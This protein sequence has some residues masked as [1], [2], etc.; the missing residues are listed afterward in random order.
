MAVCLLLARAIS[1]ASSVEQIYTAALDALEAGLDVSRSSILLFDADDV[2]RF[3]AS[4]GLS[5]TYRAAVEGHT[6]WRPDT[7]NPQ[8]IVISDVAAEPSLRALLPTIQAEG[9][10]ALS[11]I[12]LVSRCRVIG[13]FMLYYSE[14][15]TLAPDEAQLADLIAA[16]VAFAVERT[17]AEEQARLSEERLRFALDAASMGTWDW[18]LT[19]QS[20]RWSDNLE[21]LHA[22]APGT[23]DGTFASYEREI[24]PDDRARVLA[25]ARRAID[26]GIPHDVEY[27]IVGSNGDIRW[28]E[29]K[30]RVEYERGKPV[31]MTGVCM[32]VTRRKEAELARLTAAEEASRLKDEFLAMLS[33]ELRTPLNAILGWV[34]I[35]A[36]GGL[37]K[38][39]V[40]QAVDVIGRNA[41]L[42]A[43]LIEDILDVSRIITGKMKVERAPLHV[44]Q[45]VDTALNGVLPAAGAKQIAVVRDIPADLPPIEGDPKRLQQVFGNVLSNAIKFTP[46][47]G[48]VEIRCALDGDMLQIEVQDSGIGISPDF[49]PY[50]FDRFRQADSRSTRQ[51]AGLGLGLAIAHHLLEL[52]HG[53]IHVRSA[54][55]GCGTTFEIRLPIGSGVA[56]VV[57]PADDVANDQPLDLRL[58]GATVLIVDDQ[59]D[60]R[61]LL[62]ALFDRCGADVLQAS[63]AAAALETLDTRPVHLLVADLAMPDIDGFDLI[64]R[65]RRT[66]KHLPAV[67]VSAYARPEDRHRAL[68]AGYSAYCS[69][70]LE[71]TEFLQAVGRVLTRWPLPTVSRT[72]QLLAPA[73]SADVR[74]GAA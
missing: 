31:R 71:T 34:Q 13:K 67:A 62:S 22:L 38:E 57:P 18:D 44:Q 30:G 10:A 24:H 41:K 64:E 48:R 25:S 7:P 28:V 19:T 8:R 53:S 66:H 12:P 43:R 49:L 15:H 32:I 59:Q 6:P 42:Q 9:I 74:P 51:H 2:M 45:I 35:L 54:G 23:F 17:R 3:K 65:V 58:D 27:R 63:S 16:Q 61:D 56:A 37:S 20:V 33:H 11:F 1:R 21:R 50:V 5:E 36:A 39:R 4:R 52:H 14:P 73:T 72:P 40:A 55:T 29:G 47:G 70:P 46:E 60:S 26:K 68:T 69:K